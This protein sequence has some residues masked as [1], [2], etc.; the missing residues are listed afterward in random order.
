MQAIGRQP[1]PAIRAP[2]GAP[3][4]HERYR[5]EQ[6]SLYCPVQQHAASFIAPT[7]ASSGSELS[8]FVKEEFD[9]VLECGSL[10]HGFLRLRCGE[11]GHDRLLTP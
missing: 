7:E 10:A 9:A 8:R 6:T 3:V 4:H 11:C 1:N 2:D 5:R